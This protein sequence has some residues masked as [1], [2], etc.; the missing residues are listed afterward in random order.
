M[1]EETSTKQRLAF[2]ERIAMERQ[3]DHWEPSM[4]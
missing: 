4:P 2:Q 1:G 3:N